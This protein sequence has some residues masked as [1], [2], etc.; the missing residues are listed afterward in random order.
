MWK[1]TNMYL[2]VVLIFANFSL[3]SIYL[4]KGHTKIFWLYF[5][6]AAYSKKKKKDTES[7]SFLIAHLHCPYKG[8]TF[9][10]Y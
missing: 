9:N 8:F 10:M 3:H 6:K 4:K 7:V 5:V 1:K 2:P